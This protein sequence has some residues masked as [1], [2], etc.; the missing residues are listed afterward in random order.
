MTG[1][2]APSGTSYATNMVAGHSRVMAV[3]SRAATPASP[4]DELQVLAEACEA[5]G[6]VSP[7]EIKS[8][9]SPTTS[10]TDPTDSPQSVMIPGSHQD[11]EAVKPYIRYFY[12][13]QNLTLAD[14]VRRMCT[15]HNFRAT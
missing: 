15:E 11:W 8:E 5:A 6:T 12:L 3:R 13:D 4:S 14:V 10:P 7:T 1:A 2:A 9:E